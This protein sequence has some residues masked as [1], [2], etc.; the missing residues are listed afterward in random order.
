M[1]VNIKKQIAFTLHRHNADIALNDL[2]DLFDKLEK[3][4][5]NEIRKLRISNDA[6]KD[7]IIS[8]MSKSLKM[9]GRTENTRMLVNN[10]VSQIKRR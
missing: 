4:R 10:I 2:V 1:K 5:A 8:V 9:W 3:D 6:L 7:V